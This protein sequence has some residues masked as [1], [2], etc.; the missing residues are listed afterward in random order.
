MLFWQ[1]GSNDWINCIIDLN[2]DKRE[3]IFEIL[4]Q[5]IKT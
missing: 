1:T 5:R 4:L 3:N 2:I